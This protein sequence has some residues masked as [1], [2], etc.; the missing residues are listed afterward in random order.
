[1]TYNVSKCGII[2]PTVG[3]DLSLC[4]KSIPV[5]SRYKYLGFQVMINGID[6]IEHIRIQT[7]SAASFLKFV[8]I[9]CSEWSPYT[10]YVIYNTFLRPKLEYGAPL[11]YAFKNYTKF[12]DLLIPIENL[13]TEA[14]AWIFNAN[15]RKA[16]I[17]NGILGTLSV[18][19]RFSHLR[20][21]FQLHPECS[22]QSNPVHRLISTSKTDQYLFTLLTDKL[23]GQF[24]AQSDLP[25]SYLELKQ[26][27][28]QFL[29]S[30][31][32]GIISQ[33]KSV[34]IN[35]IPKTARTDGLVD[36]VLTAPI[37][38]QRTFLSWRRGSLF[39]NSKCICQERWHR[40]H[41]PCLP[42]PRL[43]FKHQIE[44]LKCKAEMSKN[45]C[46][47]DYLLNVQEWD[48][49]FEV[50]KSWQKALNISVD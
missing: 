32:S 34:L 42:N 40:G 4:G 37:Q 47:L 41:I 9:Q 23:Y 27:M 48:L 33:S 6:F 30:R 25:S 12:K 11:I 3:D 21:S 15:I 20:C 13:R 14:I 10:R 45:F 2:P 36:R 28:S 22:A 50:I 49:A 17:L 31:R 5:V 43:T 29:L 26:Y 46:K 39:L 38:Y 35:Y 44:Y 1:M 19:Q 8:Q 7:E 16:K 24:K 18:E